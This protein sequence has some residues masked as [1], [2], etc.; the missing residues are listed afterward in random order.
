MIRAVCFDMDGLLTDTERIGLDV[1]CPLAQAQG[2][3]V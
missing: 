2:F 3:P 1:T